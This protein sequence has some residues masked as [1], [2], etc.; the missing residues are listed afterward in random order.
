MRGWLMYD[1]YKYLGDPVTL[2]RCVSSFGGLLEES[3]WSDSH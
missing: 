1:T 3:M 2:A